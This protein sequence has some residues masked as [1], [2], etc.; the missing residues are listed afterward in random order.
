MTDSVLKPAEF[1]PATNYDTNPYYDENFEHTVT[2]PFKKI[3][4]RL[5][6]LEETVDTAET[7][8]SDR[9]AALE[10]ASSFLFHIVPGAVESEPLTLDKTY[11]QFLAAVQSGLPIYEQRLVDPDVVMYQA[12]TFKYM[13]SS[14]NQG[15]CSVIISNDSGDELEFRATSDSGVLTQVMN[16]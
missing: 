16:D 10:Q 1:R 4:E 7:G 8:L 3:D 14:Q 13:G 6:A 12:R 11:A 15:F 2:D 9:V 5:D